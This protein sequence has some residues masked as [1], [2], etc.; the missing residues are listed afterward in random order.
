MVTKEE[1]EHAYVTNVDT[2]Q[3]Q[4]VDHVTIKDVLNVVPVW[5]E[6]VNG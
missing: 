1:K 4:H 6:T 3:S 5:E 2:P